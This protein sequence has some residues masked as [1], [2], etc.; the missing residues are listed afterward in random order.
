M[1]LISRRNAL[2]Y[3]AAATA[4]GFSIDTADGGKR[5][6]RCRCGVRVHNKELAQPDRWG[7][8]HLTYFMLGRDT[9]DMDLEIWDAQFKLAFESWSEVC[10]LTFSQVDSQR[11]A[12]FIIGVSRRRKLGFGK[13][14]GILAWAQMPPYRNFDGQLLTVFD[15]AEDWVVPEEKGGIILRTVAAHEIGHLLGLY[16]SE[17]ETALMYPYLNDALNPRADDIEKIQLLYG[18]K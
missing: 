10:P 17:D 14:G 6:P 4:F 11:E 2:L 15:L 1:N 9:R 18:K 3:G 13:S 7:K 5:I 8:K 16:H 12:D